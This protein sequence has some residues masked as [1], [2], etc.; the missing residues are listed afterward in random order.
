MKI[1]STL[2]KLSIGLGLLG[3]AL[4]SHAQI[5]ITER[6]VPGK[7]PPIW[8]SLSGFTGEAAQVL[9][10]DLYVQ[11]FNF[12]NSEAAQYLISGSNNGNLQGR[13]TDRFNKS[14]LVSK[15]YSG[16]SVRRQVHAF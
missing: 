10:F 15:A 7:T 11:G 8:V 13:V 6:I 3:F 5:E 9:Q 4:A 14:V 2:G 1:S 12:T 16:A